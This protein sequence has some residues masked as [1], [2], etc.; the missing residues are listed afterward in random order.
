M[1]TFTEEILN[2]KLY[3]LCSETERFSEDII[4]D[5]ILKY[6]C[7]LRKDFSA[8][9]CLIRMREKW[10]ER[11]DNGGVFSAKI[12]DPSKAF[13]C[14]THQLPI[15]KL[16]AYGLILI[17]FRLIYINPSNRKKRVRASNE[18][19]CHGKK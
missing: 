7:G 3:F 13:D 19:R 17:S 15:A 14:L 10:K 5:I 6:Q 11:A 8:Q 1:V 18:Y 16:D 9:Y 4:Q 2:R 12:A